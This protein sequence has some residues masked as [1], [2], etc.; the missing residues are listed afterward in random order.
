MKTNEELN[1]DVEVI[2]KEI[3]DIK[4]NH[5]KHIEKDLRDVK[6]EVFRF[7]YITYGAIVI[8]VL[9]TDKFNELLRLL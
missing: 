3:S 8:F 9:F 5:L 4:E 6:I 1:V 7:K 2:K